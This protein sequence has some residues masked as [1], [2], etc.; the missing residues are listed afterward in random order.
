MDDESR[1]DRLKSADRRRH[2]KIEVKPVV[3]TVRTWL[4]YNA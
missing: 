1:F 4:A 2:N 3:V